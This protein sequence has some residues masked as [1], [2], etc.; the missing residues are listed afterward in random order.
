MSKEFKI[1]MSKKM[2]DI[3]YQYAKKYRLK[4]SVIARAL[5]F[6]G[7]KHINELDSVLKDFRSNEVAELVYLWVEE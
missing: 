4:F 2:Y 3:I 6:I 1:R 7:L 5:I